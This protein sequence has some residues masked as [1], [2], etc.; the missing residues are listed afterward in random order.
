MDPMSL[1][2]Q[3]AALRARVW[4]MEQTLAEHGIALWEEEP[5]APPAPTPVI[6]PTIAPVAAQADASPAEAAV[7]TQAAPAATRFAALAS[8][9]PVSQEQSLESRIGSQW[10]NRIGILAVL[11]A[12]AWF[13]KLAIDN[14]WIGPLGRVLIGLVAGAG[15]IAWSERFRTRGYAAFS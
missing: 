8:G 1:E 3:M 13:L 14:H 10:F 7:P 15:L 6:E 2:A 9:S 11:I 12:A 5:A 4:R